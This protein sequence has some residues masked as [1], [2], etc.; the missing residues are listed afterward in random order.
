MK[1]RDRRA[2]TAHVGNEP[3]PCGDAL[4]VLGDPTRDLAQ[5]ALASV[6]AGH[7]ADAMH[8]LSLSVSMVFVMVVVMVWRRKRSV[9]HLAGRAARQVDVDG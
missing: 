4:D 5:L 6:D 2:R 3:L 8:A 1:K 9:V 7:A